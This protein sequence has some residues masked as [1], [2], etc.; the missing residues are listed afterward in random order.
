MTSDT[1]DYSQDFLYT[2][3]VQKI[4]QGQVNEFVW[5]CP[6]TTDSEE[7]HLKFRTMHDP[8]G[9]ATSHWYLKSINGIDIVEIYLENYGSH[10]IEFKVYIYEHKISLSRLYP[11]YP[12][13]S[14][15]EILQFI[16]N[17]FYLID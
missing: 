4:C 10:Q 1:V 12:E 17:L 2:E 6:T 14:G 3:D 5:K 15:F 13:I 7:K 8:I 16:T 11:T 9:Y